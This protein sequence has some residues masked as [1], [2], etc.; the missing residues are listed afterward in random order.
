MVQLS[1]KG[2]FPLIRV[3]KKTTS[4]T[5]TRTKRSKRLWHKNWTV[6]TFSGTV[7][8][9]NFAQLESGNPNPKIFTFPLLIQCSIPMLCRRRDLAPV[10]VVIPLSYSRNSMA[11]HLRLPF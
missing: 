6:R 7:G 8:T 2:F 9:A 4:V 11:K 10:G 3:F 5:A 1:P